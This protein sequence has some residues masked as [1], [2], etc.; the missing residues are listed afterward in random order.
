MSIW[1]Q[2]RTVFGGISTPE[3]TTLGYAKVASKYHQID[4]KSSYGLSILRDTV[5]T[6]GTGSVTNTI[7]DGEYKLTISGSSSSASLTSKEAGVYKSGTTAEIGMGIRFGASSLSGDQVFKWGAMDSTEDNGLYFGVDSSGL[8]IEV[9]SGGAVVTRVNRSNWNGD[10]LDGQGSSKLTLDLTE[11]NIWNMELCW[12]GYGVIEFFVHMTDKV[13]SIQRKVV[14]HRLRV[15]GALSVKVPNLPLRATLSSTATNSTVNIFVSGRQYS[16]YGEP[17]RI[18][19]KTYDEVLALSI[20]TTLIPIISFR[21]KTSYGG[22]RTSIWSCSVVANANIYMELRLNPG[23]LATSSWRT[24]HDVPSTE[25]AFEVDTSATSVATGTKIYTELSAGTN[26]NSG[27]NSSIVN[28]PVISGDI[29]TLC[30]R[31]ISGNGTI[32]AVLGMSEW[33]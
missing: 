7:G 13:Q 6:T 30:A 19:R 32:S 25:T 29:I 10:R 18:N 15:L 16:I 4:L 33:W 27:Q 21:K 8:F 31:T 9:K 17:D 20:S 26:N 1:N 14:L 11:G 12:Y 22:V 28:L 24:P 23:T 3:L 2:E 5:V